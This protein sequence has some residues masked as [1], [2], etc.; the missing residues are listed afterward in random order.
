MHTLGGFVILST[1]QL[2]NREAMLRNKKGKAWC[3][4]SGCGEAPGPSTQ[5]DG[6]PAF[7]SFL[8]T[9]LFWGTPSVTGRLAW[10]CLPDKQ[11]PMTPPTCHQHV[12]KQE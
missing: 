5:A 4:V 2:Q 3:D 8:A 12:Q 6:T 10:N 9:A 11:P 1:Q 7:W